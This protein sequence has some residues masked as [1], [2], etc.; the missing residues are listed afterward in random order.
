VK[1]GDENRHKSCLVGTVVERRTRDRKVAGSTLARGAIKSTSLQGRPY[2][3]NVRPN[4]A[5]D[6][7][8]PPFGR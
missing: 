4:R 8:G 1:I 6:F 7:R 5:A 2:V 3:R